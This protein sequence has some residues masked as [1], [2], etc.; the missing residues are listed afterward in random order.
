MRRVSM[1]AASASAVS[2]V[3][4]IVESG[5]NSSAH[6]STRQYLSASAA[7]VSTRSKAYTCEVKLDTLAHAICSH[8]NSVKRTTLK[9]AYGSSLRSN[10]LVA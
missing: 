5:A 8:T 2:A 3:T 6:V 7:Y 1:A 9:A 4:Q 10:T